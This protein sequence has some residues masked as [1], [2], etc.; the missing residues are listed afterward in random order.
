MERKLASLQQIAEIRPIPNADNLAHYRINGWWVVD[1]IDQYKVGDSV[2]Y[3]EVDSWVPTELAPF[4]S[5]GKE[6]HEFNGVKG[7]RLRTI[8]LRG[9]LSQ[10]LILNPIT[11]LTQADSTGRPRWIAKLHRYDMPIGSDL[12]GILEIQKYEKPVPTQLA[13]QV[14]GN[15]PSF[16]RKTDQER[17]QNIDLSTLVNQEFEVT[18]KLD[19]SSMTI[20]YNDGEWGVCSRNINLKLDQE[21]NT[22]VDMFHKLKPSIESAMNGSNFAIQ[23]ELIGGKIQGNPYNRTDYEFYMFSLFDIDSQEYFD[24]S[25]AQLTANR[26]GLNYV[27]VIDNYTIFDYTTRDTLLAL[28]E[29]TS[30]L[31]NTPREGLV[32]KSLTTQESFKVISNSWLLKNE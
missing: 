6:P 21:G 9:A 25:T 13:G 14:R 2:I 12:T 29:G 8:K 23:G 15:F 20:Y 32:F 27:P 16:L 31:A 10:G 1:R 22:F 18:E 30:Q 28:A 5:K 17:V 11:V 7:E 26:F 4:L 19:G 3:L 24:P